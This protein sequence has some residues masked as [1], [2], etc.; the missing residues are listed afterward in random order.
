M[1]FI[2]TEK[3]TDLSGISTNAFSFDRIHSTVELGR[4]LQLMSINQNFFLT[5]QKETLKDKN[6]SDVSCSDYDDLFACL[7]LA[8]YGNSKISFMKSWR[9]R[10]RHC[11]NKEQQIPVKVRV[12]MLLCKYPIHL[13]LLSDS[14]V[15]YVFLRHLP[16]LG[17]VYTSIRYYNIIRLE[18]WAVD[19]LMKSFRLTLHL[20]EVL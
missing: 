7:W 13:L 12:F 4:F 6:D 5:Y 17:Y 19:M 2:L 16:R 9:N 10:Y 1:T 15:L 8:I 18:L 11:K 3:R 14:I 20:L